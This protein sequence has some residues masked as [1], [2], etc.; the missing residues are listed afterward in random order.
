LGRKRNAG[1]DAREA[2]AKLLKKFERGVARMSN[3][4]RMRGKFVNPG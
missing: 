2:S 4:E 3:L 1:G